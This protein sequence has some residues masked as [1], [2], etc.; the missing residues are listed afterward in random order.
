VIVFLAPCGGLHA[1]LASHKAGR[2]THKVEIAEV[3]VYIRDSF[4]FEG[5]QSLGFWSDTPTDDFGAAAAP[6]GR[7]TAI[8]NSDYRD[9]R[10]RHDIGGDF[11]VF[12]DL[13]R[14]PQ[15]PPGSFHF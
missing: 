7:L 5:T 4:D 8:L 3:G 13:K 2:S 6:G 15:S 14:V 12:S 10:T 9:W 1:A 11:L